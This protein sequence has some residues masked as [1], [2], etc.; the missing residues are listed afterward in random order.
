MIS[1]KKIQESQLHLNSS[2]MFLF[3]KVCLIYSVLL[4]LHPDFENCTLPVCG[5]ILHAEE[6]EAAYAEV[7]CRAA[8]GDVG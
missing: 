1:K 7:P 2:L 4:T 8:V 5:Q 3:S 6:R